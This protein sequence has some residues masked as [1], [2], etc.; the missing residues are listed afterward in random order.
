[1]QSP[2]PGR[3]QPVLLLLFCRRITVRRRCRPVLRGTLFRGV[4]CTDLCGTVSPQRLPSPRGEFRHGFFSQLPGELRNSSDVFKKISGIPK[5]NNGEFLILRRF[6]KSS[7]FRGFRGCRHFFFSPADFLPSPQ[8]PVPPNPGVVTVPNRVVFGVEQ[9]AVQVE[10]SNRRKCSVG[11]SN[12]S[13]AIDC[14][15]KIPAG[16]RVLA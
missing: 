15:Y 14:T 11:P 2:H 8:I 1:M 7:V 9:P 4:N 5:N 6:P 16:S 10:G 13:I 3:G 12:C